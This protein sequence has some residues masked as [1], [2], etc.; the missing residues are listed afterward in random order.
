LPPQH[1]LKKTTGSEKTV[2]EPIGAQETD[3][4]GRLWLVGGKLESQDEPKDVEPENQ[5]VNDD[6]DDSWVQLA[7]DYCSAL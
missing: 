3:P 5:P 7:R 1:V 6:I 4:S 2:E